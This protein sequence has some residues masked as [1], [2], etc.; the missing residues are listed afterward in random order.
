MLLGTVVV[1][2]ESKSRLA[3]SAEIKTNISQHGDDD[4][5][6]S[7]E[8]EESESDDGSEKRKGKAPERS[9]SNRVLA[10]LASLDTQ[11]VRKEWLMSGG[12]Q[13]LKLIVG[14]DQIQHRSTRRGGRSGKDHYDHPEGWQYRCIPCL[15]QDDSNQQPSGLTTTKTTKR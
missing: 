8:D 14:E 10:G 13:Q 7:D 12:H 9:R 2:D 1:R 15:E 5:Q 11:N 6:S 3:S 4:E